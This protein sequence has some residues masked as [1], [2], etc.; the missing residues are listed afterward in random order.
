MFEAVLISCDV[1]DLLLTFQV[2]YRLDPC[3]FMLLD[4]L[5]KN[6]R[7]SF[8]PYILFYEK[9][10]NWAVASVYLFLSVC[11]KV[12]NHLSK[13]MLLCFVPCE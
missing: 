13:H 10:I 7:W 11:S 2:V 4:K 9:I 3:M 8:F 12:K 5:W 6:E 1:E